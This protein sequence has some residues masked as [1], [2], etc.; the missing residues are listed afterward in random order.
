MRKYLISPQSFLLNEL[1]HCCGLARAGRPMYQ[2]DVFGSKRSGDSALLTGVQARV[3]HGPRWC[4]LDE[5]GH[6]APKQD[7][8]KR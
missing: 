8:H 5:P 6:G 1:H 4:I 7:V 2:R 3:P